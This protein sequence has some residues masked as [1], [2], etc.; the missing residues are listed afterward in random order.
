MDWL[1]A[2]PLLRIAFPG[3]LFILMGFW[4]CFH[5]ARKLTFSRRYR[6][7]H[8]LLLVT[9][10]TLL[11]RLLMPVLPVTAALYAAQEQSGVFHVLG[12]SYIVSLIAGLVLLDLTLYLQHRIFHRVP[13]LW[14]LHRMHHA[15]QD[16]DVSTGLRFHPLEIVLSVLIKVLV[17]WLLGVPAEA[18]IAFEVLLSTMAVFNH[19]NV[20]LPQPFERWLRW[21]VVTPDMHRIHH[22]ADLRETHTNFGFNLSCWDRWLGSYCNDAHSPLRIGVNGLTESGNSALT[23][24]LPSRS[25]MY[26]K[27]VIS[28]RGRSATG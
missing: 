21:L 8:N 3:L 1:S 15:D 12:L 20:T 16:V 17:V 5:P 19:A 25:G 24:C 13:V 14:R 28:D 18:V 10:N 7:S 23:G 11:V 26:R 4:E 6:W 9:L 27:A 2:E 22:S